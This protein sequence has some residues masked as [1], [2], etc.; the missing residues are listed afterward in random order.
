MEMAVVGEVD[1]MY[2][3]ACED[4]VMSKFYLYGS[5]HPQKQTEAG[6]SDQEIAQ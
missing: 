5:L 3:V 1:W 4:G 6:K 2:P